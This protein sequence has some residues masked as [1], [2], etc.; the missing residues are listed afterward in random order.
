MNNLL[1]FTYL[2]SLKEWEE[3]RLLLREIPLYK[4]FLKKH[5]YYKFLTFGT[6][7]DLK[8]S[9]LLD[10]IQIIPT[11]NIINLR[12]PIIHFINSL[13]L[14]FKL[15]KV[16]K[17]IHIVKTNQLFGSWIA[18]MAKIILKKKIIIRGGYELLNWHITLS[19]KRGLKNSIKYLILYVWYYLIE[20]FAY[21]L[22]DGIILTS[23]Y[24]ISF[25][26]K[27]FKLKKKYKNNK[28][29]LIYN[30]IDTNLFKPFNV[31][32]KDK[33]VLFIGKLDKQ[34]NLLNLI[35]A[36]KDLKDFNLDIIGEGPLKNIL[37]EYIRKENI[38]VKLLGTFPNNQIPELLNQY[39]LFILP[40][41]WEGNPKV[42]LEA[43]S[44]GVPCI[45]S[46]I[47][48]IINIIKHKYN[49]FLCEQ[50]VKS[51]K[52]AIS[53]LYYDVNLM[54]KISKNAREFVFK[55]CSLEVVV[56]KEYEFYK[57]ILQT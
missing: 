40:S 31:P 53:S 29:R 1:I 56:E 34:K 22:A 42:L 27:N 28:I 24:D 50:D 9:E 11:Q 37:K 35:K 7:Q 46:N 54:K 47:P 15:K 55:Y 25:I 2:K 16:L 36:F 32:K 10:N 6:N 41:I 17:N 3:T 45:A 51:I 44:C 48:G 30:F 21:K 23:E 52:D 4:E 39:H 8:Y 14:P 33:S 18:C 26:I 5:I 20:F 49:G 57:E 12:I 13:F 38:N 43:M 19:E